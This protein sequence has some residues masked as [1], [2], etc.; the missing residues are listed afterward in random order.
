MSHL[1]ASR[2]QLASIYTMHNPTACDR[3][4]PVSPHTSLRYTA[5]DTAPLH[6]E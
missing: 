6:V 2:P 4:Y 1:R 3:S 5:L